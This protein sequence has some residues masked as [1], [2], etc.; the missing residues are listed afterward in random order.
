MSI[1][2]TYILFI[3][4]LLSCGKSRQNVIYESGINELFTNL[5]FGLTNEMFENKICIIKAEEIENDTEF[6][7]YTEEIYIKEGLEK[8]SRAN[9]K[10]IVKILNGYFRDII[11]C[12]LPGSEKSIRNRCREDR[13]LCF[14]V[15]PIYRSKSDNDFFFTIFMPPNM[16]FDLKISKDMKATIVNSSIK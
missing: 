10:N 11:Q 2:I 8:V 13:R 5:P 3:S 1:R 9:N 14:G 4:L 6:N 15:T 7:R 16:G 12:D